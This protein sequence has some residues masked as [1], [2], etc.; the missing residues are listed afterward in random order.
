MREILFKAKRADGQG[1]VFGWFFIEMTEDGT[2]S[3][4]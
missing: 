4:I 3:R 1:W 2:E